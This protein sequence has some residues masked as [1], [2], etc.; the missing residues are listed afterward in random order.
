MFNFKILHEYRKNAKTYDVSRAA[1]KM[2]D[3]LGVNQII[4]KG[5]IPKQGPLLIIANHISVLDSLILMSQIERADFHFIALST[6]DVYGPETAKK[7]LPI[8]RKRKLNHKIYEYPLCLHMHGRL[9]QQLS[10][11]EIRKRNR[12]TISQAAALVNEGKAVSIFPTGSVGKVHLNANWKIGVGYLVKEISNPNT[13]VVFARI[14]GT[15]KSDLLAFLNPALSRFFFKPNALSIRFSETIP[16][17]TLISKENEP[18]ELVEQ[19]E[20]FHSTIKW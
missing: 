16:L 3:G 9:P 4:V 20:K 17:S 6:Y 8:Y 12:K 13:K 7:L 19:L 15:K 2:L 10:V 5:K 14:A 11:Q 18:T 1:A